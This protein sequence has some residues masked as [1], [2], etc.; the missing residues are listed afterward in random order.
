MTPRP[1]VVTELQRGMYVQS[2]NGKIW[3]VDRREPLAVH[4]STQDGMRATMP[5]EWDDKTPVTILE[6][7]HDEA[8]EVLKYR[9]GAEILATRGGHPHGPYKIAPMGR[10]IGKWHH[11]MFLFHGIH[12]S[13][14][15]GSKSLSGIMAAHA[16]DHEDATIGRPTGRGYVDHVH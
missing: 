13:T 11:H 1:G 3:R 5:L 2:S 4:L 6:P 16:Q 15:P 8:L 10:A 7:T 9:I 14:G 12:T